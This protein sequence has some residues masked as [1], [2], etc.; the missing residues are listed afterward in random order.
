MGNDGLLDVIT[1]LTARGREPL[2]CGE[3]GHGAGHVCLPVSREIGLAAL[4]EGI[5]GRYGSPRNLAMGG[6][7]DPT[8]DATAGLPLLTPFGGCVVDMRAWA[9][10]SCWIGA[11]TVRDGDAVQFI[12]VIAER[13]IPVVE[14]LPAD[15]SWVEKVVA[16]TGWGERRMRTVDWAAVQERLG[17]P[18]PNDYKQLVE[19]FGYGAFDSFLTLYV[20]AARH[21]SVDIVGG[22]ERRAGL[23]PL[24]LSSLWEPYDA[25]PVPGGLLE[26]GSSELDRRGRLPHAHRT[27]A[28][29]L[30]R[31]VLRCALVPELRGLNRC[32]VTMA[33]LAGLTMNTPGHRQG[34]GGARGSP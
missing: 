21:A 26:W 25:Y 23:S 18:L 31:S 13:K 24:A 7:V 30:D 19:I 29:F 16:V 12:V 28:S 33:D 8:A 32:A 10:G 11:G 1:R 27:R 4:A 20:P 15:A 34:G 22:P 17:T 2:G 5:S 3:P 14:G 9:Y 6:C